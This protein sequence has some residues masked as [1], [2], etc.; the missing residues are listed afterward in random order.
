MNHSS[1]PERIPHE[2][3]VNG[4]RFRVEFRD[5]IYLVVAIVTGIGLYFT[6]NSRLDKGDRERADLYDKSAHMAEQIL[7][8]D[9]NGTKRSHETDAIQQQ[10]IDYNAAQILEINRT[11][12]DLTPKVDK[13]DTNVLWLMAKQLERK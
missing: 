1:Q 6:A 12:R 10:Q 3:R 5:I 13:I 11:L 8:L 7:K 9:A 2:I 4:H